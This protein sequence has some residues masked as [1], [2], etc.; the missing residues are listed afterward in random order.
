[1]QITMVNA[2]NAVTIGIFLGPAPMTKVE[3]TARAS[4]WP[5]TTKETSFQ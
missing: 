3:S 4:S 1:M 5:L 2:A